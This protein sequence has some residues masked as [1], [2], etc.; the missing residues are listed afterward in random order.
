MKVWIDIS[1]AP[2]VHF[3]KGLIKEIQKKAEVIVTTRTFDS[4]PQILD[5]NNIPYTV[6]G[7]HG[8]SGVKEKLIASSKRILE[9][10]EFIAD[11]DVD[12]AIFKHS[13]EAPRVAYGLQIPSICV[14]DNEHGIAQNKLMLP[15]STKVIAPKCIPADTIMQFGVQKKNLIQFNGICE[16]AHIRDFTPDPDVLT[17][18]GLDRDKRI[19]VMRPEPAKANYFNGDRKKTIIKKILENN[20]FDQC[21]VFPR[22]DEQKKVLTFPH[23]V[24]PEKAV[25]TLSLMYYADLVISAGGSMNREAVCC[26]TPAI[27]TYPEKLLSVTTYLMGLGLKKHSVNIPEIFALAKTLMSDEHYRERAQH[28]LSQME[29]PT[30]ILL[31]EI[32][33]LAEEDFN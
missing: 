15:L 6:V 9:L 30:D 2:H 12:L 26:G 17:A 14:M 8:G 18:L 28:I 1:N 31:R 4:V 23:T 11:Q 13:V 7:F 29:D 25:D 20:T 19:V 5:L 27:S 22:F 16:L 33:R 21:V 10:T 24:I 32:R 3:F